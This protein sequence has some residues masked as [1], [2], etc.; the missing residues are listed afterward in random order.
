MFDATRLQIPDGRFVLFTSFFISGE[1]VKLHPKYRV[2]KVVPKLC[3]F[4]KKQITS[5]EAETIMVSSCFCD[6]YTGDMNITKPEFG[7]C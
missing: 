1:G 6:A 5:K 2:R 7:R 3:G 4:A